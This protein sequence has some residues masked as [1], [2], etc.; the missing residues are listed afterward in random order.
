MNLN[1]R[2]WDNRLKAALK[3]IILRSMFHSN[4]EEINIMLKEFKPLVVEWVV[5]LQQQFLKEFILI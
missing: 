2:G 1:F 3:K 4:P 5:V